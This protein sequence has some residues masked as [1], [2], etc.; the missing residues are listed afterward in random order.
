MDD[1]HWIEIC[2]RPKPTQSMPRCQEHKQLLS[3][4]CLG[5]A[6]SCSHANNSAKNKKCYHSC[7]AWTDGI[8]PPSAQAHGKV[9]RK[10]GNI[11]NVGGNAAGGIGHVGLLFCS[12]KNNSPNK[13]SSCKVRVSQEKSGEKR[14]FPS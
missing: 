4:L 2:H 9:C 7:Q 12:S 3:L 11:G 6:S 14:K 13:A 1:C 5:S 10:A 8:I